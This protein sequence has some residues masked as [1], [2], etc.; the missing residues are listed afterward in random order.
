MQPLTALLGLAAAGVAVVLVERHLSAAAVPAPQPS[1][2]PPPPP[3]VQVPSGGGGLPGILQGGLVNPILNLVTNARSVRTLFVATTSI[4]V[5]E[6]PSLSSRVVG[7]LPFGRAVTVTNTTVD[8]PPGWLE[9][10]A[11]NPGYVCATCPEV[12]GGPWLDPS[13]NPFFRTQPQAFK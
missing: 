6:R 5:Y 1:A 2:G 9:L 7:T 11:D 3:Q 8:L 10:T 13:S 12:P 4:N